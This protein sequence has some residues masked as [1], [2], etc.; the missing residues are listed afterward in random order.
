MEIRE[1]GVREVSVDIDVTFNRKD[2]WSKPVLC[3]LAAIAALSCCTL[4]AQTI[5][6]WDKVAPTGRHKR[7]E[8]TAYIPAKEKNTGISV[9]VCPGG[10]YHHLA[11][12]GEGH[13]VAK[14]LQGEGIA[15]F[16]LRYRVGMYGNRHPA[17]IQDLQRAIALVKEMCS[18]HSLAPDKVGVMG[19]S[20]GGHLAGVAATY[21]NA[22]FMAPLGLAPSASLRPA[23][24]AMIYPV[25]TMQQE[26][27][28]HKRSRR[29]LLGRRNRTGEVERYL[30]LELHAHPDMPP[31]FLLHCKDDKTVDYRNSLRYY[32][33]L[34]EKNVPCTLLLYHHSGHGFGI[35][36]KGEAAGWRYEFVS[37]TKRQ[38]GIEN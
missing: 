37:W 22:N 4:S 10:S 33:A 8:L 14:F 17:M 18:G 15:A 20:A 19:F 1:G 11:L 25:V 2:V 35:D 38:L 5:K 16:V 21:F 31:V 12:R 28:V 30:S 34:T 9:I 3:T 27:L 29:N 6:I 23:F 32:E 13:K 24:V 26:G 36:P 7:S